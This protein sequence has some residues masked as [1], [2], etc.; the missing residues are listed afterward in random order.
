MKPNKHYEEEASSNILQNKNVDIELDRLLLSNFHFHPD[1]F[2]FTAMLF[3]DF[4]SCWNDFKSGFSISFNIIFNLWLSDCG[5][6]F[7]WFRTG[8]S[9][10]HFFLVYINTCIGLFKYWNKYSYGCWDTLILLALQNTQ[11][12]YNCCQWASH[13]H[14]WLQKKY[15]LY[16][17]TTTMLLYGF[18]IYKNSW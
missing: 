17:T 4:L 18:I 2:P 16:H 3:Y 5:N 15:L 12:L 13:L 10:V 8:T 9:Q 1:F 6:I 7:T 14:I 11:T